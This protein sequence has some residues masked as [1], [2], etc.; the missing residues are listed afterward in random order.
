MHEWQVLTDNLGE[1]SCLDLHFD[2]AVQVIILLSEKPVCIL[3]FNTRNKPLY[4]R[5]I[6]H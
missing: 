6:I 2:V 3:H 5:E 4:L 1:K